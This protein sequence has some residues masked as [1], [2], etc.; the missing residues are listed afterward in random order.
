[1]LIRAQVD[2]RVEDGVVAATGTLAREPG[3]EVVEAGDG[4][5]IPGLHDHHVHLRA[6]AAASGSLR[7]G[8]D[9]AV[10]L[11]EA[12]AATA[13]FAAAGGWVRAVGYHPSITGELDRERLDEL[14]PDRPVRVQHRSGAL[15]VLNSAGLAAVG[16]D[17]PDGK[18]W[19]RDRWLAERIPPT[20][21][22][23][24]TVGRAAAA[25]G[26][27]GMTDADPVRA[28]GDVDLLERAGLPQRLML[29]S[30]RGLV[31]SRATA[32]PRKLLLDD[33]TLS[34]IDDIAEWI[35]EAH[36]RGDAV[37]VHCVT[38][39]QLVATLAALDQAGSRAGDRIEHG[40]VVPPD[41]RP[42]LRG[43]AVTVVT[44]PNFVAERGDQYR[45]EV[46]PDDRPLLYPCASLRQAGVRTAAGTDAPFGHADPWAAMR[47]AVHRR[48]ASGAVLGPDERVDPA[49]ALALFLGRPDAPATP[50]KIEPGAVADLCVLDRPLDALLQTLASDGDRPLNP[51]VTTVIAGQVVHG[52][53]QGQSAGV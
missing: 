4:A 13:T 45:D 15:W 14:V 16:A 23:L 10:Q 47:A 43:H 50:R 51:V 52:Q 9:F 25:W 40:G 36:D 38:R 18:L 17:E 1:M 31:L 2:V 5:V 27:T 20:P 48:T 21:L 42:A 41:L 49:T 8:K 6:M 7:V 26:V 11:R 30:V 39:L 53:D 46:D 3:E 28:Q 34:P 44:Q 29:M 12:A 22:D 24:E 37:A 35:A 19:R 32:G 33:A